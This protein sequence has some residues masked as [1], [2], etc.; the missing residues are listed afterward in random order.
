MN[1]LTVVGIFKNESHV[2]KEWIQHYLNEGADHFILIDNGSTDDYQSKISEFIEDGVVTII[3]DETRWAQIELYNKYFH[4][5]KG[6]SQWILICDLDEFIYARRG[7]QTIPAFLRE[8]PEK[9]GVIRIP[10]KVFGSSENIDQPQEVIPFFLKR[11]AQERVKKPWMPDRKQTLSKIIVRPELISRFHIHFCY[12]N[13]KCNVVAADG[14]RL[15]YKKSNEKKHFQPVN[16]KVL[17]KSYLHL[18]HYALQSR[19]WFLNV[20]CQRGAADT[21]AHDEVRDIAYFEEYDL[22]SNDLV[23]DELSKKTY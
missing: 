1:F 13:Q 18:N 21:K 20:K 15:K 5:L 19:N 7:F 10:W 16:E 22:A 9:V 11:A 3:R 4:T 2:I 14:K 17:E 6:Q 12:L 8:L 23:D